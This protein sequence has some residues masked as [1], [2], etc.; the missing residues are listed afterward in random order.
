MHHGQCADCDD[1][2]LIC[3]TDRQP[4]NDHSGHILCY[5]CNSATLAGRTLFGGWWWHR[6]LQR[7]MNNIGYCCATEKIPTIYMINHYGIIM[8]VEWAKK[9]V[10]ELSCCHKEYAMITPIDVLDISFAPLSCLRCELQSTMC[11]NLWCYWHIDGNDPLVLWAF[12]VYFRVASI[13]LHR[14][15][16]NNIF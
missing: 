14:N 16:I 12:R 1:G 11:C 2:S 15:T 9:A 10:S 6:K 8:L 3:R 13:Q 5:S 7:A 4:R